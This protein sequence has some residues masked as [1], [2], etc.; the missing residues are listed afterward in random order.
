MRR[1]RR[2]GSRALAAQATTQLNTDPELSILLAR[3]GELRAPTQQAED[4]LRLALAR[5]PARLTLPGPGSA[6]GLASVSPDGQSFAAANAD[7]GVHL[8]D[9][10]TGRTLL[11]IPAHAG[12]LVALGYSASGTQ[13]LTASAA[14]SVARVWDV[15]SG[16][17][18][19][20]LGAGTSGVSAAVFSGNAR[21][22]PSSCAAMALSFRPWRSAL[23][24]VACCPR[25]S[26]RPLESGTWLRHPRA[27]S[28][29][30]TPAR[31]SQPPSITPVVVS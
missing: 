30:D 9:I 15:R 2:I 10:A 8:W 31:S 28:S 29:A 14:D 23:T 25:A 20:E 5:S 12:P 3:E 1:W 22:R 11:Q 26:I 19:A 4:A 17:A 13:L 7:G 6:L 18:A 16:A 21:V 27:W 24:T